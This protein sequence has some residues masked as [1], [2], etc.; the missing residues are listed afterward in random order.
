MAELRH[1][2]HHYHFSYTTT[3]RRHFSIFIAVLIVLFL[4][5]L[6]A[7]QFL[8][9]NKNLINLDQVSAFDLVWASVATFSRLVLAYFLALV[10]SIP[11]ALLIT[12]TPRVEKFLLPFF[13]IIQSIPVLAFFPIVVLVFVKISF[14]EGAAIFIIF[15]SMLWNI[16]FSIIGGL[17]TIPADIKFA[18]KVFKAQGWQKLTNVTIPS[19]FPYL[20]TGSLLAWAQGWNIII[21]AE[22]L[23]SYIPN[24]SANQDL[25]GLGSL[26]V[27][28][29]QRGNSTLFLAALLIM[30]VIIGLLNILVW[31][32]LLHL[33]ERYKFD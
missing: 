2:H 17:K 8:T 32:K 11:L 21:V 33:A 4:I 15:A 12:S 10:L 9:P 20:M 30:V 24:G 31:Q 6:L 28:A 19:I 7:F 26:L 13:D 27:S 16:V 25:L 1:Y 18:A 5:L 29:S 23:H 3:L 22:V 14:F